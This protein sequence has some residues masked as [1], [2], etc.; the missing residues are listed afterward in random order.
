VHAYLHRKEGD[1]A[2]QPIGTVG[3]EGGRTL[4]FDDLWSGPSP[5][6]DLAGERGCYVFAIKTGRGMEPIYVGK[7]TK[8]L[9]KKRST[10]VTQC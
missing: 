1:R 2:T 8:T 5:A 6:H 3:R 7:A 9:N 4:L 10:Q